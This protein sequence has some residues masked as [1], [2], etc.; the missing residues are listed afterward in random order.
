MMTQREARQR[1]AVHGARLTKCH[2]TGEYV[3]TLDDWTRKE[4]D[5]FAYFTDDLEDAA[6]TAGKLRKEHAS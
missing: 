4:R 3:V 1:C 5:K 2:D 6:L